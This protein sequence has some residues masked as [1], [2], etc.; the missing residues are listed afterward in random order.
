ME[1]L[2]RESIKDLFVA[3]CTLVKS[4]GSTVHNVK[5]EFQGLTSDELYYFAS[6]GVDISE[7]ARVY[8]STEDYPEVGELV[9]FNSSKYIVHAVTDFY[10]RGTKIYRKCIVKRVR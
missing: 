3:T 4:D 1:G 6:I 8:F 7:G 5:C 10:F 2:M 9:I